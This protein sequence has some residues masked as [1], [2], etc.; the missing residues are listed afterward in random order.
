MSAYGK[1]VWANDGAVGSHGEMIVEKM[2]VM[3]RRG[4]KIRCVRDVGA[5]QECRLMCLCRCVDNDLDVSMLVTTP[6]SKIR[7]K[8]LPG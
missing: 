5:G 4:S 3:R 8:Y 7:V 2:F 6:D 1:A